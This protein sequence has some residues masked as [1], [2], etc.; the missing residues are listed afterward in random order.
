MMR[1]MTHKKRSKKYKNAESLNYYIDEAT[2]AILFHNP[3][4]QASM[5]KMKKEE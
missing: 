3:F 2:C 5:K 4:L 1:S